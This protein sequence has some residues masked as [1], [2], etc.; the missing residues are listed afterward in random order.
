MKN[1][2]SYIIFAALGLSL[3]GCA[4]APAVKKSADSTVE[5]KPTYSEKVPTAPVALAR[6]AQTCPSSP[7]VWENQD[8]RKVTAMA[9]ACVKANDWYK[10][11]TL[12]NHLSVKASL[13]PWGPYYLALAAGSR[14][15][16]P[17]AVWML[18]LALKKSPSEGLFHYELGRIAWELGDDAQAKQR[19]KTASD[20]SPS[21]TEAHWVVGQLA[22]DA[23]DLREAEMR[24]RKA[25][26]SNSKHWPSI[27]SMAALK[28][29]A[30]DWEAAE[31]YLGRGISL[32]PRSG[33][34]RL[35]LA[36]LQEQQLKK[37][38]EAISGY[39]EMRQLTA[40]KSLDDA[41]ALNYEQ[42]I[43]DL[44]KSLPEVAKKSPTAERKPSADVRKV[45]Q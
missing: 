9:N 31:D 33:K 13:T 15:D 4:S 2:L 3:V 39:K 16:Y 21:L 37:V 14:K 32:N 30:K 8:W 27:M 26:D 42:K 28:I 41:P 29:K 5:V 25:L 11:E 19:M 24:L 45:S 12:G 23:Q 22:V 10:V 6:A 38:R 36:Q 44:E 40:T 18:E 17:R 34:A 7:A 43:K 35:A 20:L 1:Q